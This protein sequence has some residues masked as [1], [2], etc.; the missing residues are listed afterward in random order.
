M[1]QFAVDALAVSFIALLF[2]AFVVCVIGVV[3]MPFAMLGLAL[4]G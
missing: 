1:M 4:F 3:L 2:G